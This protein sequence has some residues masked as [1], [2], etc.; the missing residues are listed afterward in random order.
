[1][2][3]AV[4]GSTSACPFAWVPDGERDH[5]GGRSP[6]RG[7]R[8]CQHVPD[9]RL[10]EEHPDHHPEPSAAAALAQRAAR[11]VSGASMF[12]S[13][14]GVRTVAACSLY[15]HKAGDRPP[16]AYAKPSGVPSWRSFCASI[17]NPR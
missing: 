11:I 2:S 17:A 8:P 12:L 16:P 10:P 6:S 13:R 4:G 3:A 7:G 9:D 5:G 15:S 14:A 1:L